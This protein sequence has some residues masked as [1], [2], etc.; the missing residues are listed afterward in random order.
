M[1]FTEISIT[2][3]YVVVDTHLNQ[4]LV[5]HTKLEDALRDCEWLPEVSHIRRIDT[6]TVGNTIRTRVRILTLPI[7]TGGMIHDSWKLPPIG[8][9]SVPNGWWKRK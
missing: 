1:A 4:D 5:A 9:R 8:W 7:R 2:S 3:K 6:V